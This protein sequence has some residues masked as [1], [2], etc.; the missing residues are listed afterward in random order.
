MDILDDKQ[1]AIR[2]SLSEVEKILI[3]D[4][5]LLIKSSGFYL[6]H[7]DDFSNGFSCPFNPEGGEYVPIEREVFEDL[8]LKAI[9]NGSSTAVYDSYFYVGSAGEDAF[10]SYTNH[11][12]DNDPYYFKGDVT[13]FLKQDF[14][15][16]TLKVNLNGGRVNRG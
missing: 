7:G 12:S 15:N 4:G 9:E 14:S 13:V 16:W 10:S 11:L 1:G 5:K 8:V 2:K 6:K 3:N